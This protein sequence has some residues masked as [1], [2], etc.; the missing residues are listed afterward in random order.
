MRMITDPLDLAA[1]LVAAACFT[2]LVGGVAAGLAS[3]LRRGSIFEAARAAVDARAAAGIPGFG[4]L[5]ELL[6]CRLCLS[7]QLALWLS[8]AAAA[9][10][11]LAAH[12][13]A[14]ALVATFPAAGYLS[15]RAGD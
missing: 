15:Y 10:L 12:A 1:T 11:A 4:L 3:V 6:G 5:A 8:L 9:A 2:L 14:L 13:A 7:M